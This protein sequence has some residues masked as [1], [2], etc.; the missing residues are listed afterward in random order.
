MPTP[1]ITE[2][3]WR[4][5]HAGDLTRVGRDVLLTLASFRGPGGVA[6][7]AHSTLAARCKCSVRTVQ[8]ALASAKA[9][10][11]LCW[12][13]RWTKVGWRMVRASNC[14]RFVTEK[15][16]A[17]LSSIASLLTNLTSP[18]RQTV[19]VMEEPDLLALRRV[20]MAKIFDDA[21]RA[22]ADGRT[23]RWRSQ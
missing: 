19:R 2:R 6:W 13:G 11:L 9:L 18:S 14:Y 22:A 7:P 4:A 3:I 17:P 20:A 16:E 8:K 23:G 5:F 21:T 15:V 1:S 10:G 12:A